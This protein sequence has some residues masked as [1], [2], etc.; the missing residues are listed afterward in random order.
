MLS[1]I[2]FV[3]NKVLYKEENAIIKLRGTEVIFHEQSTLGYKI[4]LIGVEED[5]RKPPS[6]KSQICTDSPTS[7]RCFF[8]MWNLSAPPSNPTEGETGKS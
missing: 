5:E 7:C 1:P 2:P 4:L 6:E 8:Y 3:T